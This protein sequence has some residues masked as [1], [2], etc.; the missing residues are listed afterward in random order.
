MIKTKSPKQNKHTASHRIFPS[1]IAPSPFPSM[2]SPTTHN[3]PFPP[4]CPLIVTPSNPT[5]SPPPTNVC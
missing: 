1:R 3:P 2:I 5:P 4:P